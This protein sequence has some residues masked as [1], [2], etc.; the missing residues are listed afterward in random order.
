MAIFVR[1]FFLL[2]RRESSLRKASPFAHRLSLGT[3][4]GRWAGSL[5]FGTRKS[6]S[7]Y[8]EDIVSSRSSPPCEGSV[9]PRN[10]GRWY[11]C[12]DQPSVD[13]YLGASPRKPERTDSPSLDTLSGFSRAIDHRSLEKVSDSCGHLLTTKRCEA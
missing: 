3:R 12:N 4:G 10:A 6:R 1:V 9:V 5:I 7:L 11:T 2:H 8:A 13:V